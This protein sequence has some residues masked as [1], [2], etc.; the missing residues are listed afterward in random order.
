L[1]T[2]FCIS[3]NLVY[4]GAVSHDKDSVLVHQSKLG[5]TTLGYWCIACQDRIGLFFS[6]L[7]VYFGFDLKEHTM[8]KQ[9]KSGG[10]GSRCISRLDLSYTLGQWG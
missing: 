9:L 10:V 6:T 4:F 1:G 5:E 7:S 2:V 8:M 3:A